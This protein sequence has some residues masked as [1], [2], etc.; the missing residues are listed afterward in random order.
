MIKLYYKYTYDY[1]MLG[2]CDSLEIKYDIENRMIQYETNVI[3]TDNVCE[4]F[5]K[6]IIEMITKLQKSFIRRYNLEED[7]F[8][9]MIQFG[10]P[11]TMV[12]YKGGI[13]PSVES[14]YVFY[15]GELSDNDSKLLLRLK[16]INDELNKMCYQYVY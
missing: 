4:L 5:K 16:K 11:D 13:Y 14:M 8:K 3:Y 9:D 15:D 1:S 2:C 12:N 6:D 7:K 10:D